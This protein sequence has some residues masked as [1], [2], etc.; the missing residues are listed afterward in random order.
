MID[1]VLFQGDSWRTAKTALDA[2]AE[3]QRVIASNIANAETPG[4]Q[5]KEVVFEELLQREEATKA[6]SFAHRTQPG[7]LGGLG[8]KEPKPITRPRASSEPNTGVNNVSLERETTEMAENT[9]HF[10]ALAQL[11]ANKYRSIRDAIRPGA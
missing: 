6:A 10:Q 8:S 2:S 4:Y 7:H 9:L 1:K 11:L 3:R 5:A